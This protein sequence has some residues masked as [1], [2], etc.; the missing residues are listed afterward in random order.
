MARK[1]KA[2]TKSVMLAPNALIPFDD[3]RIPYPRVYGSTKKNGLRC[4]CR[5]GDFLSRAMLPQPN[6]NLAGYLHVMGA[7]AANND[8]CFD[9]E[10]LYD[11]ATHLG[12]NAS[13]LNSHSKPLND[14]APL[15]VYVFDC[16]TMQEW[17]DVS[18]ASPFHVRIARIKRH[19][20]VIKHRQAVADTRAKGTN[21]PKYA[22]LPQH[23]L[24]NAEAAEALFDEA[25]EAGEEGI[26][27]RASLGGYKQARC[28][29]TGAWLLKFKD[30]E[31]TDGKIVEVIQMNKMREGLDRTKNA[32]GRTEQPTKN[33]DNY[34]VQENVGALLVKMDDGTESRVTFARGWDMA[35]RKAEVWDVR[36]KIIGKY[37]EFKHYPSGAKDGVQSGRMIKFRPDKD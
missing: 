28:G 12:S 37:V 25:V 22:M 18:T 29:H 21:P 2:D 15:S 1:A 23:P 35:R 9:M 33:N 7:Y 24:E 17:A 20:D 16:L 13:V 30:E 10:L 3:S 36:K 26:M 4:F 19:L 27:L 32:W 31:T 14:K 8:L 11:D 34:T 6:K 5:A